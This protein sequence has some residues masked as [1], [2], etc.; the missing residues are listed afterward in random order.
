MVDPAKIQDLTKEELVEEY[1][2]VCHAEEEITAAKDVLRKELF[3]RIDGDGEVI[4]NYS[5]TKAKRFSFSTT[6]AEAKLLGAVKEAIDQAFL[7]KLYLRGVK[8]PGEVSITEYPLIKTIAQKEG[9][10]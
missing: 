6:L 8:I 2:N 9:E 10:E 3:A 7:K 1:D 5:I 4:G